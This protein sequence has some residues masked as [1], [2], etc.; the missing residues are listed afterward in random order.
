[1]INYACPKCN[2]PFQATE[3]R[4]G[5]MHACPRCQASVQVPAQSAK[6]NLPLI[7]GIVGGLLILGCGVSCIVG[8]AAIQII[9]KNANSAF[10]TVGSSIGA[11]VSGR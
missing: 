3:D 11:P 7:L 8:L 2:E 5:T 10:G 4:I 9:G 6:S 1:M